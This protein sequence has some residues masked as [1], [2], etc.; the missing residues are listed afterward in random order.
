MWRKV[1]G[2]THGSPAAR[3]DFLRR[4]RPA[5]SA[6]ARAGGS[7]GRLRR[8]PLDLRKLSPGPGERLERP[9]ALL[10]IVGAALAAPTSGG[11][12]VIPARA[13]GLRDEHAMVLAAPNAD[14]GHGLVARLLDGRGVAHHAAPCVL[15]R[16][17]PGARSRAG[18]SPSGPGPSPPPLEVLERELRRDPRRLVPEG[19]RLR[20]R[21]DEASA[22][23]Q[24]LRRARTSRARVWPSLARQYPRSQPRRSAA[25]RFALFSASACSRTSG[26]S[27]AAGSQPV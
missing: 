17:R 4:L 21:P 8:R 1:C 16:P 7:L 19:R 14:L 12:E 9:P 15:R 5:A 23:P 2:V 26:L 22:D 20:G 3:A 25:R 6:R 27:A 18:L 13:A 11:R 10:G 24:A